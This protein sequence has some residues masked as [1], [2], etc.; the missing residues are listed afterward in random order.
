MGIPDDILLANAAGRIPS[1]VSLEYLAE[2]RDRPA[3]VAIL[4]L[5]CFTGVIMIVRLYARIWLV[6]R[7]GLDDILAILTM[8][9]PLRTK[10]GAKRSE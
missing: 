2:S 5:V 3:L 4:F 6:K 9:R 1:G 7:L 10:Y 8:V